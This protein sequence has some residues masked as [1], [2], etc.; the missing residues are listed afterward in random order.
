MIKK[1]ISISLIYILSLMAGTFLVNYISSRHY[2]RIDMT[3]NNIYSLSHKSE[4]IANDL[5]EPVSIYVYFKPEHELAQK[6]SILLDAYA[7]VSDQIHVQTIDPYY[8][9]EILNT[10]GE[11][12][13]NL[14]VNSILLKSATRHKYLT[15][16]ELGNYDKRLEQFG[17]EP[18]LL[19]FN[20]EAAITGALISL[21]DENTPLIGLINNH[22]EK[23]PRNTREDGISKF[24]KILTENG[25]SF[26]F[27]NLLQVAEI[28]DSVTILFSCQPRIDFSDAELTMIHDWLQTGGSLFMALDPLVTKNNS[29]MLNFNLDSFLKLYGILL[30]NTIVVDP[31]HQLP[32]SRPDNLLINNYSDFD[33]VKNMAGI[34]TFFFQARSLSSM[35]T[36]Y[37]VVAPL[38]ATSDKSWGETEFTDAQYVFDKEKDIKGPNF[39]GIASQLTVQ[40]K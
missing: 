31:M 13:K 2:K 30:E 32:Y 39:I 29:E 34:T 20:G 1:N 27:I 40:S 23:N 25:F 4:V 28:P 37:A 36:D 21:A 7:S 15:H 33:V 17:L 18:K 22:Q 24:I 9:F 38:L 14:K 8:D 6:L 19:S 10:L 12:G 26:T 11:A 5:K 16:K 3:K 35:Q